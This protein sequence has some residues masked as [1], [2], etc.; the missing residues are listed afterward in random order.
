MDFFP[1]SEG[2]CPGS[3]WKQIE[4]SSRSH[5]AAPRLPEIVNRVRLYN[6]H[7]HVG[8]PLWELPETLAVTLTGS[9]RGGSAPEDED[10]GH[11]LG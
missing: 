9:L 6:P 1:S 8:T 11:D 5:L 2:L 7:L 3:A 10:R 4:T